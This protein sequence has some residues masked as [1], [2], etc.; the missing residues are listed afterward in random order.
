MIYL[1]I[2]LQARSPVAEMKE[3]IAALLGVLALYIPVGKWPIRYLKV[4]NALKIDLNLY[5]C[6]SLLYSMQFLYNISIVDLG[7]H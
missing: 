5:M 1:M 3:L 4:M 2:Y 7:I 6:H